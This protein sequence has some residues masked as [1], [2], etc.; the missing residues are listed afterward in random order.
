MLFLS[1]ELICPFL[2]S[3]RN[4]TGLTFVTRRLVNAHGDETKFVKSS[5]RWLNNL[6]KGQADSGRQAL[7]LQEVI[8]AAKRYWASP[9]VREARRGMCLAVHHYE[10]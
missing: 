3:L 8:E 9:T 6:H 1:E 4:V 2:D 10:H 5:R 7:A